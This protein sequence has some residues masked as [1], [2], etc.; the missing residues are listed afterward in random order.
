MDIKILK[1]LLIEKI[2]GFIGRDAMTYKIQRYRAYGA[3]IGE[4]VRAF[5]PVSSAESYLLTVGDN[6]TI[7][8]GVR[9]ITHDNS[10][11]KIYDDATDFVG[12][13]TIGRNVFIG[14]NS[15][16]LPGISIADNCIIGAGAVVTKSF[17]TPGIIIAGNPAMIIGLADDMKQK[18]INKKFDFRNRNRRK[19]I[20]DNPQKWIRK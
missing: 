20:L 7:A 1:Y 13:I 11:I 17:E 8:T 6:V 9:F 2:L 3:N 5:S 12:P 19:V 4:N 16:L 18:Y 10:A 15:V 14:A